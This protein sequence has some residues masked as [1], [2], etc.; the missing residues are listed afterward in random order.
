M[1]TSARSVLG[2]DLKRILLVL[3]ASVLMAVN[4]KTFV[5]TGGLYPG[6]ATGLTVLIQR[7]GQKYTG[8]E[9]PYTPVNV[10]LN[11]IPVYIGFRYIGKR[12]TL[13]S[14]MMILVNGFLVDLIPEK[15][16][17]YDTLLISIFGGLINGTVVSLC[18]RADATTGGTDFI[19]IFLSQK[20]GMETWNLILGLNVIILSLAGIFFG[21][22]KALYSII[23]QFV[24]TQT[25]HTLYRDYQQQT[26]IIVTE[27]PQEICDE[28]HRI[29]HHGAT[30]MDA[31]GSHKHG[32][33]KLVYS[34]VSGSD[35]KKAIRAARTI[36][37]KAF[38]NSIRTTELQGR[39][40]MRP[41]D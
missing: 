28:I 31:E 9:I 23:F 12:F 38:V 24:S 34:V 41:K 39:F 22:D 11:A 36:D 33:L 19:A 2:R 20:K 1:S 3:V 7:L 30:I 5:R 32:H 8:I 4:I 15:V 27:K 35:A 21:W 13:L 25:V 10:L 16:I 37:P 14:L 18:L 29:C 26:L 17:T 40:Y 6:G